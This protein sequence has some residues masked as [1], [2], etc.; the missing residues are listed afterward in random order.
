[1]TT[2]RMTWCILSLN[3]IEGIVDSRVENCDWKK[4]LRN[5][6]SLPLKW[7][8]KFKLHQNHFVIVFM[9]WKKNHY[10]L[11][12]IKTSVIY[13]NRIFFIYWKTESIK[14]KTTIIRQEN[15]FFLHFDE[16][17][18]SA[19]FQCWKPFSFLRF[20]LNLVDSK[21]GISS[22]FLIKTTN[23]SVDN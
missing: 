19:I 1:M 10:F 21:I 20:R 8:L 9:K 14:L 18:A 23:I 11:R 3:C 17:I 2:T 12:T 16:I 6:F 22:W 7:W 15:S 5:L 4:V 13:R